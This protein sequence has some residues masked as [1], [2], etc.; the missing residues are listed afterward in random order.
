MILHQ[1]MLFFSSRNSKPTSFVIA[2]INRR[3]LHFFHPA[4]LDDVIAKLL[5]DRN[6]IP[7]PCAC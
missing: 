6:F 5:C 7:I 2:I 4:L 1:L 3:G